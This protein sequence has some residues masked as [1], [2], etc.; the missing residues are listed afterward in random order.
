MPESIEDMRNPKLDVVSLP[1]EQ[2]DPDP[3]NPNELPD[4]MMDTLKQDVKERGFIQPIVVREL[5]VD[6]G[7]EQRYM[8]VDGEHRWKVLRDLGWEVV[9]SVI[10]DVSADDAKLRNIT[11]NRLRGQLVPIK[12]ALLLAD[13]NK[14][15]PED[16]LARRLGMDTGEVK[17]TLRLANFTDDVAESV[18]QSTQKEEREAPE[19]LQFVLKKQDAEVVERVIGKITNETTDRAGA[20]VKL[21][22][23]HEKAVS[24]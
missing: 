19:V 4:D 16:E 24:G 22:R 3:Q 2:I 9:P 1:I 7:E 10:L 12:L 5:D 15:I 20:L 13:L 8:L 21:C 11:M 6:E 17:D 18:R 23:E 14:R